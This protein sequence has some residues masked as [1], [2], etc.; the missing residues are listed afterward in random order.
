MGKRLRILGIILIAAAVVFLAWLVLFPHTPDPVYQGKA[1]S[2]WVATPNPGRYDASGSASAI[3]A[4]RQ[5]GTNALPFLIREFRSRDALIWRILPGPL[6]R[7]KMT[8]RIRTLFGP[9]ADERQQRAGYFLEMLGPVAKPVIPALSECLDRPDIA[10]QAVDVLGNHGQG[11]YVSLGPEA[12]LPLLKAM[13]NGNPVVRLTAVNALGLL[14]TRPDLVVPVL[15][16]ALKDPDPHVRLMTVYAFG[17]YR[18]D[19]A[20]IVPALMLSLD[21]TDSNV[22]QATLMTLGSYRTRALM[23]APKIRVLLNDPDFKV[24]HAA[25]NA[26]KVIDTTAAANAG[27]K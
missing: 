10:M 17:G 18:M 15:I 19:S 20:T 2:Q 9:T 14:G 27:I 3:V 12:T 25:T 5:M 16:N 24:R 1:L 23:S 11:A 6:Y 22:R 8:G 7:L 26:L 13:T 21:D 4:V